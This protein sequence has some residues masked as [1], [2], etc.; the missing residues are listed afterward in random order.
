MG[1]GRDR[2]RR[3]LGSPGAQK[4]AGGGSG[5]V[6]KDAVPRSGRPGAVVWVEGK[7]GAVCVLFGIRTRRG[8]RRQQDAAQRRRRRMYLGKGGERMTAMQGWLAV[9]RRHFFP[10]VCQVRVRLLGA[11]APPRS[12]AAG[13]CRRG[14]HQ[15]YGAL[16]R[17]SHSVYG[18]LSPPQ[19]HSP[20][21][22][23]S[24]CRRTVPFMTGRP[25]S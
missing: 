22:P 12:H 4:L 13:G 16:E 23:L 21:A 10:Q 18:G 5:G 9:S 6:A 1:E 2:S 19:S 8:G 15:P 20:A 14:Q 24:A 25:A 7:K 11:A 3:W 17:V